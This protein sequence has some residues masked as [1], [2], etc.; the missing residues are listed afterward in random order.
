MAGSV[1]TRFSYC[2]QT[3]T[4]PHTSRR[5]LLLF[6]RFFCDPPSL[7]RGCLSWG[8]LISETAL[9]S[10]S[11]FVPQHVS[12][13]YKVTRVYS[14]ADDRLTPCRYVFKSWQNTCFGCWQNGKTQAMFFVQIGAVNLPVRCSLQKAYQLDF[15][16]SGVGM[17]VGDHIVCEV[18]STKTDSS[19][20]FVLRCS[21]LI[22]AAIVDHPGVVVGCFR[23]GES[24]G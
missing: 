6:W 13:V 1:I 15:W 24:S 11:Q 3:V 22:G 20:G 18:R 19:P 5:R 2:E 23:G 10:T 7:G 9:T 12:H 4:Y 17:D 14:D 21:S 16:W 8:C